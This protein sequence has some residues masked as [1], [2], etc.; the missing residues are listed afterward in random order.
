MVH[1]ADRQAARLAADLM[2][3]ITLRYRCSLLS[4]PHS[5]FDAEYFRST[6]A[7][8]IAAGG[9]DPVVELVLTS[10]HSHRLR[11]VVEV[12][13]GYLVVELHERKSEL[14]TA[15]QSWKSGRER[16][17]TGMRA[18]VSFDSIVM[19]TIDPSASHARGKP[20]FLAG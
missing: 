13:D 20:G 2:G 10:G 12:R 14:A 5:K 11:S 16:D 6:L 15:R 17:T 9:N 3:A 4:S 1:L 8:D 7:T 18:V 19:V